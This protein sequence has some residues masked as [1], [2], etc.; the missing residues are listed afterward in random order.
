MGSPEKIVD[1]CFWAMEETS[2]QKMLNKD[3]WTK[4][5]ILAGISIVV[6]ITTYTAVYTLVKISE[7][8]VYY[9]Q[10]SIIIENGEVT[11]KN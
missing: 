11:Y 1:V 6:L 4:R 8:R 10:E 2:R 5:I 3:K 9:V 7:S